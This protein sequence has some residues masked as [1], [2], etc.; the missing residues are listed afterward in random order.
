MQCT[1]Y[2]LTLAS[3]VTSEQWVGTND[4]R[5]AIEKLRCGVKLRRKYHDAVY[6]YGKAYAEG[7]CCVTVVDTLAGVAVVLESMLSQSSAS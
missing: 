3:Q 6:L 1:T 5:F 2:F 7:A 4:A